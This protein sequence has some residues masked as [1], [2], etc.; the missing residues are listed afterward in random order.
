MTWNYTRVDCYIISLYPMHTY[1]PIPFIPIRPFK[2]SDM[3]SRLTVAQEGA[4]GAGAARCSI[5]DTLSHF[6]FDV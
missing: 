6:K 4:H 2:G 3:H 1:F 5:P